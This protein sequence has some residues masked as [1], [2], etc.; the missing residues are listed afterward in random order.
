NVSL[1]HAG[2]VNSGTITLEVQFFDGDQRGRA[3]SA[4]ATVTL[5]PGQWTQLLNPLAE[6]GAQNGWA[7]IVRKAGAAPWIPYS[8]VHDGGAPG[9][10]T[11]DGAF[12]LATVP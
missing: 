6:R 2:A 1:L 12:F 11:A 4:L 5:A 8:G 10:P 9:P 7:T 3:T